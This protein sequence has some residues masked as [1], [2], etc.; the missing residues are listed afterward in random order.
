MTAYPSM[1]MMSMMS[2]MMMSQ[3]PSLMP[4]CSSHFL[5][6]LVWPCEGRYLAP[7]SE[8]WYL[9]RGGILC[10]GRYLAPG[11]EEVVAKWGAKAIFHSAPSMPLNFFYCLFFWVRHCLSKSLSLSLSLP[12][13]HTHT[14]LRTLT[15]GLSYTHTHSVVNTDR[16]ATCLMIPE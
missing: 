5:A 14:Q 7:G 12:H 9:V 13:T 6:L 4:A 11:S 8:G 16:W 1:M 3:H 2:T 15:D 10:E